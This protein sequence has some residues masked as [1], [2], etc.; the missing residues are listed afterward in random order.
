[1]ARIDHVFPYVQQPRTSTIHPVL[2]DLRTRPEGLCAGCQEYITH[3]SNYNP[4]DAIL[5]DGMLLCHFCLIQL[6]QVERYGWSVAEDERAL[7]GTWN[8][9][10]PDD[11][12]LSCVWDGHTYH[13]YRTIYHGPRR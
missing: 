9:W 13:D 10:P 1:M 11:E 12:Q 6:R 2:D 3:I 7:P 4:I 8:P 5:H